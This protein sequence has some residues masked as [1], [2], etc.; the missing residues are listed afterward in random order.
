MN[1]MDAVGVKVDERG[2]TSAKVNGSFVTFLADTGATLSLLN[3]Q[4]SQVSDEALIIRG[5]GVV[6]EA[7]KWLSTPLALVLNSKSV[8]G[9]LV[10]SP[11]SPFSLLGRD[12]FQEFGTCISLDPTGIRLIIIGSEIV[13]IKEETQIISDKVPLQLAAV[14]KEL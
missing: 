2:Q 5:V 12:L 11:N 9:R 7:M 6:G 10:I 1:R 13:Q 4:I 8:W 3:F 14:P